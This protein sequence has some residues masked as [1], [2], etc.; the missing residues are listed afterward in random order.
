M[1]DPLNELYKKK[2]L[3]IDLKERVAMQMENN[4]EAVSTDQR[5]YEK[6]RI[7]FERFQSDFR[8][9]FQGC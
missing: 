5:Y 3:M 7:E 6:A 4:G 8:M 9:V 1:T 2:Q